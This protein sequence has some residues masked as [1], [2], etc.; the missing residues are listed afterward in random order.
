MIRKT[1]LV[2]VCGLTREE[3]VDLCLE[4]GVDFTGFIFVA[5]SPRCITPAKAAGMPAG[6][7]GRVGVFASQSVEEVADIMKKAKLDFAQLHGGESVEFCKRLGPER[8]IRTFWPQRIM[9]ELSLEEA[10][11]VGE[12]TEN[13]G[14]SLANAL[15]KTCEPFADVCAYFLMDSGLGGGGSGQTQNWDRLDGFA[16]PLPWLLAGGIGPDNAADALRACPA[17]GLDCN[18]GVEQAPGIKDEQK[19]RRLMAGLGSV[20][21]T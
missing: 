18:S 10:K 5:G 1:A 21:L 12:D 4:L 2:K 16:S 11:Q 8:V 20:R 9:R 17:S 19:L 14:A 3:D 13:A 15:Q 6:K 7:A